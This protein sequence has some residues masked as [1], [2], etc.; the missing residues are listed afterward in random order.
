[1][2]QSVARSV[3][4]FSDGSPLS[5]DRQT[6]STSMQKRRTKRASH[7]TRVSSSVGTVSK[8]ELKAL[9]DVGTVLKGPRLR[10]SQSKPIVQTNTSPARAKGKQKS[11]SPSKKELP[12]IVTS[13]RVRALRSNSQASSAVSKQ[14]SPTSTADHGDG[15]DESSRDEIDL[16]ERVNE[17]RRERE[18]DDMNGSEHSD[19]HPR[20]KRKRVPR[21]SMP[22]DDEDYLPD[23]VERSLKKRKVEAKEHDLDHSL[24]AIDLASALEMAE[25]IAADARP[26]KKSKPKKK[27]KG[28]QTLA[29]EPVE[30]ASS[31]EDSNDHA[32][33]FVPS[34]K[35]EKAPESLLGVPELEAE[36]YDQ[37]SPAAQTRFRRLDPGLRAYVPP[38]D[39]SE[40]EEEE[41]SQAALIRDLETLVD[42]VDASKKGA[43]GTQPAETAPEAES[44]AKPKKAKRSGGG[45]GRKSKKEKATL[46][47]TGAVVAN[48]DH[49]PS[50]DRK[51][52]DVD[53]EMEVEEGEEYGGSA[54]PLL[55]RDDD[56]VD[57]EG[58]DAERSASATGQRPL[59]PSQTQVTTG[60]VANSTSTSGWGNPFNW[61]RTSTS[62]PTPSGG[63][64]GASPASD[65]MDTD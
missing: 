7:P 32:S 19:L 16:L 2:D 15:S 31:P 38:E 39:E 41:V 33:E 30:A 40:S 45:G 23:D 64:R 54:V 47:M 24:D 44:K 21:I 63:G 34:P 37:L 3:S 65:K 48:S 28:K 29:E 52:R 60:A 43:A 55:R 42:D 26:A 12:K 62:T 13:T 35:D 10:H 5:E 36:A 61:W 53:V 14:R 50:E 1:M 8:R 18:E 6:P 20:N 17:E 49:V 25:T 57:N 59:L 22:G 11:S 27:K 51:N 46:S 4:P 56:D 9:Q 58:D